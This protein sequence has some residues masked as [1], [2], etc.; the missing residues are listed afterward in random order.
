MGVTS[1]EKTGKAELPPTEDE[2]RIHEVDIQL[3]DKTLKE[4]GGQ[5]AWEG[6]ITDYKIDTLS[7]TFREKGFRIRI[8]HLAAVSGKDSFELTVKS[9]VGR[10]HGG[11]QSSEMT[12]YFDD[13][14]SV[15]TGSKALLKNI[16]D[17]ESLAV[18]SD[19]II[20]K[21]IVTKTR[22]QYVLGRVAFE[23]DTL[24]SQQKY[25]K[26]VEDI[27]FVPPYIDVEIIHQNGSDDA[28]KRSL[29][30]ERAQYMKELDLEVSET[31]PDITG[32]MIEHYRAQRSKEVA[33]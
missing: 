26:E 13:Y 27:S 23:V 22:K 29:N 15:I 14:E 21:N 3:L 18:E 25:G 31:I 24:V 5:L 28:E 20:F 9:I 6:T 32:D 16:I 12:L 17:A 7:G 33:T 11:I 2:I 8:R 30:E 10:E 1:R 19:Q 4:K